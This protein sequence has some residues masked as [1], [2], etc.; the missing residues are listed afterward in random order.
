MRTIEIR[1]HSY[2]KKGDGRGRGSHLSPEGVILARTV[3]QS[4]G[5]FELV[6]TSAIPRTLETALAMGFAV[7][8][9][10]EVLGEIPSAVAEEIG[11]HDRWNWDKPFI[12][13]AEFIK[14]NGPTAEMGREQREVWQLALESVPTDAHVLII[15]HGRV[16]ESGL[17]TCFPDTDFSTWGAPFEHCE[18]VVMNYAE[19]QFSNPQFRRIPKSAA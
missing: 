11:H 12:R 10:L 17:A 16:I 13:F 4:L 18:G 9:Q 15:S 1:R 2:T 19:G 14:R 3:G 8:D 5:P 6:L 7:S